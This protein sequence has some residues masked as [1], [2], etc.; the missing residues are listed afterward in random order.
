M[1]ENLPIDT[2]EPRAGRHCDDNESEKTVDVEQTPSTLPKLDDPLPDGGYGWI[3]VACNFFINGKNRRLRPTEVLASCI[4][5]PISS[6]PGS[7][8]KSGVKQQ[9]DQIPDHAIS[10]LSH[11]SSALS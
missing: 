8:S 2:S 9:K 3:C 5:S 4:I 1:A 10:L 7:R 6:Q 11:H